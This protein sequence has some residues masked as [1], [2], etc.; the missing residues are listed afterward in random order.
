M[1]T[2]QSIPAKP[3]AA[4]RSGPGQNSA[5]SYPRLRSIARTYQRGVDSGHGSLRWFGTDEAR[6]LAT[7]SKPMKTVNGTSAGRHASEAL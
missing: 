1:K 4:R 7:A 3:T 2:N 6:I 5:A